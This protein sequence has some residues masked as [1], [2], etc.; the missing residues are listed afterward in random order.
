[1]F[2][3]FPPV[4]NQ[5]QPPLHPWLSLQLK[6]L[7]C[8]QCVCA[9]VNVCEVTSL[10]SYFWLLGKNMV[11]FSW[12]NIWNAS[13]C[14]HPLSP[15]ASERCGTA[16][17]EEKMH[18]WNLEASQAV[19]CTLLLCCLYTYKQYHGF[20]NPGDAWQSTAVVKTYSAWQFELIWVDSKF[21]LDVFSA[22]DSIPFLQEG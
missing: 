18:A 2:N 6:L 3:S 4:L 17:R 19:I 5:L 8:Q 15:A 16:P 14:S 20:E 9:C 1:M 22:S 12:W 13:Q 7:L 10:T 21:L 11:E